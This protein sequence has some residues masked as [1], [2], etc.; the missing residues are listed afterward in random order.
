MRA[1]AAAMALV[2]ALGGCTQATGASGKAA[3]TASGFLDAFF[4]MD[5]AGAAAFCDSKISALLTDTIPA[6]EY[7]SE[8]I[9]EKALE[10]SRGTSFKIVSA[11]ELHG[12]DSVLVCYEIHPFGAEKG[13][14]LRRT[15]TLVKAGRTFKIVALE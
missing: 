1:V 11:S 6:A 3:K 14:A 2:L 4:K 5:Y 15:M 9:R 7:P 8:Q 13:Q 12:S 10:A